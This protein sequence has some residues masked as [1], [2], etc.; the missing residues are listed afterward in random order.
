MF[1]TPKRGYASGGQTR[2]GRQSRG[3]G[4]RNVAGSGKKRGKAQGSFYH[5]TWYC[6]CSPKL[7]AKHLQSKTA[8]NPGRWF[9]IC[10]QQRD[11]EQCGFFLW[12]DE[13][14]AAA[15]ATRG[16]DAERR[17]G[18]RQESMTPPRRQAMGEQDEI[19]RS[20][21]P[22]YQ[23]QATPTP[24]AKR[25]FQQEAD[26][27]LDDD[28]GFELDASEAEQL[29]ERAT[30]APFTPRK[31]P[32]AST[33]ATPA[34]SRQTPQLLNTPVS[35]SKTV[36]PSSSEPFWTARGS[37]ATGSGDRDV[38]ET[39][40]AEVM[41]L[42]RDRHVDAGKETLEALQSV[43]RKHVLRAQGMARGREIARLA[44]NEKMAL[45]TELQARIQTLE[46]EL[47]T[48]KAIMDK[49]SWQRETG[50]FE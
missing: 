40:V 5:D 43:L 32:K 29:L 45:V 14:A 19:P 21:P 23:S 30:M 9:Y 20:P 27:D 37:P 6:A 22:V 50:Q 2:S 28:L 13:A 38:G 24:S 16:P 18:G 46:A 41:G 48:R 17:L 47:E 11:E 44:L 10:P 36:T 1:T 25:K 12:E 33:G 3:S 42:L 8:R 7:P 26:G 35:V 49:I 39:L 4:S 31:A 34:T 15:A